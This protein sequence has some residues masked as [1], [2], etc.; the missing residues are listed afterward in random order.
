MKVSVDKKI[1]HIMVTLL[2]VAL[3][4]FV[5]SPPLAVSAQ[6]DQR[7]SIWPLR[8]E[9]QLNPGD[10]V[11]GSVSVMNKGDASRTVYTL[12]W[13]FEA[14]GEEGYPQFAD[15]PPESSAYSL[16]SWI[17][18][19]R[20]PIVI[21]PG[22]TVKVPFTISVPQNAEPGGHYAGILIGQF[23]PEAL[24]GTGTAAVTIG[25]GV[26]SL[27]LLT[28][29]GEIVEEGAIIE[30]CTLKPV[31]EQLPVDFIV[32]FENRGNVHLKPQ[33]IIEIYGRGNNKLYGL[34]VNEEAGNVLPAS[35]RQF[36]ASWE[37]G[38]AFGNYKAVLTLRYGREATL[39]TSE[40]S[41]RVLPWK[42]ITAVTLALIVLCVGLL[43]LRK[44]FRFSVE[45]R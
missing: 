41:F 12:A 10:T 33:G 44:R 14:G 36:K 3:I 18:V 42:M 28:V 8:Q 20:E 1:A 15:T 37:N 19:S 25:S 17:A 4:G 22:E 7:L 6:E 2:W 39:V 45:R 43:L 26:A 38:S 31:H 9:Y 16:A 35:I 11:H 32:G 5:A 40:L 29:A 13:D 34:I 24:E 23:S 30:F 27:I 21:A